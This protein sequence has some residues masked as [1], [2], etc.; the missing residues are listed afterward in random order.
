MKEHVLS[1]LA[2]QT[3]TYAQAKSETSGLFVK[4][5]R[6]PLEVAELKRKIELVARVLTN[7]DIAIVA[8]KRWFVGISR[9]AKDLVSRNRKKSLED[10]DPKE[11]NPVLLTYDEKDLITQTEDYI[12]GILRREIA[13][14]KHSDFRSIEEKKQELKRQKRSPVDLYT[15]WRAWEEG[16]AL[17]LED[18][19]PSLAGYQV[20]PYLRQRFFESLISGFDQQ[21]APVQYAIL[22]WAKSVEKFLPDFNVDE[23][24]RGVKN[25]AVA[26]AYRKTAPFIHEYVQ[27]E[28]GQKAFNNTLWAKGW[29]IFKDLIGKYVEEEAKKNFEEEEAKKQKKDKKGN[30]GSSGDGNQGNDKKKN[31]DKPKDGSKG[32]KSGKDDSK[33]GGNGGKGGKDDKD[34]EKG[35]KGGSGSQGDKDDKSEAGGETDGEKSDQRSW[36]SLS[37]SEKARYRKQAE[38][39]LRKAEEQFVETISGESKKP[40]VDSAGN[41][42][43]AETVGDNEAARQTKKGQEALAKE[44]NKGDGAGKVTNPQVKY[45]YVPDNVKGLTPALAEKYYASFQND[46]APFITQITDTIDQTFEEQAR[47]EWEGKQKR[48]SHVDTD[49][50]HRIGTG[51]GDVFKQRKEYE[52]KELAF[53][54]VIDISGSMGGEK[55]RAAVQGLILVA[56]SLRARNIAFEIIAFNDGIFVVKDFNSEFDER[57]RFKIM[58]LM[59]QVGGGTADGAALKFASDRLLKHNKE[60]DHQGALIMVTD[61]DSPD[62]YLIQRLRKQLGPD[63]PV[64]GVGIGPGS[65]NVKGTFSDGAVAVPDFKQ[66]P[67][68]FA[69]VLGREIKKIIPKRD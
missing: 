55:I 53:S 25:N 68:E 33:D 60:G 27:T 20:G 65:E 39:K 54:L 13:H 15:I 4:E 14:A 3:R 45:E 38:E 1:W 17:T 62:P 8:G 9:K 41:V 49:N 7:P 44:R 28:N 40:K 50:L 10:H 37:E 22:C 23:I 43:E 5:S 26:E 19:I 2:P 31:G 30:K 66:L 34:G 56:E 21:P 46:V 29:P 12:F 63:F 57:T 18:N 52:K 67:R 64:L 6:S 51:E 16:R 58:S 42:K 61:G 35:G 32:G 48:G 24:A 36:D 11:F 47:I 69:N 59:A